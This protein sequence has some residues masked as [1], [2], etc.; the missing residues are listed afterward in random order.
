MSQS[1]IQLKFS[2][3]GIHPFNETNKHLFDNKIDDKA[4]FVTEPFFLFSYESYLSGDSFAFRAMLGF[5]NDAAAKPAL[6]L[7]IGLKQRLVQVWRN[8]FS[9]GA[10]ANLYGR[11]LWSS[12]PGYVQENHWGA[13]GSWEYKL[14]FMGELEY[15][16]FLNDKNDLTLSLLYGHQQNTFTF[17]IG[18]KYWIS[19]IIKNPKKCGNC[20]F[21]KTSKHWNP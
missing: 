6:T 11:S 13:N 3:V 19:S 2:P 9:I 16:L 7:H 14:G 10:G 8:S 20:P 4:I 5:L 18:Y 1:T 15:A 12:I 17:T 21:Q